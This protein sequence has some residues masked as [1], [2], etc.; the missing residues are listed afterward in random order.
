MLTEPLT[1]RSL[2]NLP[3][4]WT[5]IASMEIERNVW[6]QRDTK[7][8]KL[9]DRG[10]RFDVEEGTRQKLSVAYAVPH[11]SSP[12]STILALISCGQCDERGPGLHVTREG[13]SLLISA[14]LMFPFLLPMS[15]RPTAPLTD[16]GRACDTVMASGTWR[17]SP[18]GCLCKGFLCSLKENVEGDFLF[19][20][21]IWLSACVTWNQAKRSSQWAQGS[22]VDRQ[23]NLGSWSS[24]CERWTIPLTLLEPLHLV[25][26]FYMGGDIS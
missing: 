19:C 13:E 22:Q 2:L 5:M 8:R 18:L 24:W 15:A 14:I 10:D 21:W 6:N 12:K 7:E 17:K 23:R 11:L 1:I 3:R 20:L 25:A 16:V 26:C 4:L 9:A